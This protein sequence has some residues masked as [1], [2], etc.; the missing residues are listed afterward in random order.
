MYAFFRLLQMLTPSRFSFSQCSAALCE[1]ATNVIT[2]HLSYY[3][4]LCSPMWSTS[5]MCGRQ[6]FSFFKATTIGLRV[7]SPTLMGKDCCISLM[8]Q[9]NFSSLP[10]ALCSRVRHFLGKCAP[11]SIVSG[12][13]LGCGWFEQS[14]THKSFGS[15]FTLLI[16]IWFR[17]FGFVVSIVQ[18]RLHWGISSWG[19]LHF[20]SSQIHKFEAGDIIIHASGKVKHVLKDICLRW[21][22][23]SVYCYSIRATVWYVIKGLG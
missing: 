10:K 21:H 7:H 23:I 9:P 16:V 14:Q 20:L 5:A 22:F 2:C 1:K 17:L 12:G 15:L 4:K 19:T 18:R 3:W 11:T 6:T 8:T 13:I